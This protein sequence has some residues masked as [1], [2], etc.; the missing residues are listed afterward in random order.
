[1]IHKFKYKDLNIVL[2]VNS[3]AVH[4]VDDIAYDVLDFYEGDIENIYNQLL[5]K[6]SKIEI[7]E[8][9]EDIDT[10]VKEETLFAMDIYE[11][12]S[13]FKNKNQIIKALCLHVAHDCNLTCGY[14]FASQGEFQ[15]TRSLMSVDTGKRALRYLVENSGNRYNLEVD[16][17]GGE[18]L[19]NFNVVKELVEYGRGIEKTH[20]KHFRFTLTTNGVLLNDE[21]IDYLNE[22]MD[23]VV[24]SLDGR[25]SV[26]DSM[27]KFTNGKGSYDVIVPKIKKFVKKRNNKSY[28]IRG[29]FTK[30]NL[31]FA[32]DILHF[33]DLGFKSLSIEPVVSEPGL[34]Y[35]IDKSDLDIIYKQYDEIATEIII[36]YNKENEFDFFHLK[37]DLDQG[38]CIIKRLSGCGAGSEY[39]AVTPE[40]DIYPC[41]QFVGNDDFKMGNIFGEKI[42]SEI[43]LRF[44]NANIY[45]KP[46][47]NDCWAKF[48]CSGGCHANAY[49]FNKDINIPYEMGCDMERKRLEIAIYLKAKIMMEGLDD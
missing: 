45:N 20:K 34:K 22:N 17:F 44:R 8:A 37:I 41:H 10:L 6:Y 1:M 26:N 32:K 43:A 7:A 24:L 3:G 31:D 19:M 42:N 36:R 30:F 27:R 48:Y 4:V 12:N 16:F 23:N 18:P 15:G 9:I 2:D 35:T 13:I 33:S 40:G 25:K 46:K 11:N 38:P 21:I 39:I 29:T 14:C 5:S 28:Y 49:N 47:C